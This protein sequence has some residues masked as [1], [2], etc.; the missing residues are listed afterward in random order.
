METQKTGNVER[1]KKKVMF[2]KPYLETDAVW[3]PIRTCPY[4]GA[5]YMA[6]KLKED[7]HEV[8]Y[9]D[10]VTRMKEFIKTKNIGL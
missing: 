8:K 10:E 6:S 2:I 5:W 3:D 4:I 9:L 1:E 7:G